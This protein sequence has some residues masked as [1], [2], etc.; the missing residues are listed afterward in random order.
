MFLARAGPGM[1]GVGSA[2]PGWML[3]CNCYCV[4]V[5]TTSALTR[6][7][8]VQGGAGHGKQRNI[9]HIVLPLFYRHDMKIINY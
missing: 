1:S 4:P 9:A 2:A 6:V 8:R 7:V 5:I 3:L